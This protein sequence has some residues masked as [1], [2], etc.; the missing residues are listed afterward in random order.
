MANLSTQ[1]IRV[2][3]TAD[4][5]GMIEVERG[6]VVS[7]ESLRAAAVARYGEQAVTPIFAD[8][9]DR[10]RKSFRLSTMIAVDAAA[11]VG[12]G[13]SLGFSVRGADVTAL[14]DQP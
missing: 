12:R 11:V 3:F 14:F 6:L 8:Y 4:E 10:L 13:V 2:E 5:R 1:L 9:R 7:I